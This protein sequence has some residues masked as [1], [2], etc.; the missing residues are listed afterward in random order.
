MPS[1]RGSSRPKDQTHV[2]H[3]SCIGQAGSLPLCHL[4]S[5]Y[6]NQKYGVWRVSGLVNLWSCWEHGEPGETWKLCALSLKL[7]QSTSSL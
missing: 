5:S 3:I 1:S 4:E 2:S 7:V 6:K